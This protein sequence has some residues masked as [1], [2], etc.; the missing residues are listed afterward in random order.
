MEQGLDYLDSGR[1][2]LAP[3]LT[4]H[5]QMSRRSS[6]FEALQPGGILA[7]EDLAAWEGHCSYLFLI[8]RHCG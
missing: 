1:K 8:F 2:P 3:F 7:V 6:Q 4:T 5:R